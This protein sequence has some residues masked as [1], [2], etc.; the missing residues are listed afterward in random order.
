M[1]VEFASPVQIDPLAKLFDQYRVFYNQPSDIEGAKRFLQARFDNKD[2][3]I[4]VADDDGDLA[5]FT[6]IYPS[7]SSVAMALIWILN[8]LYVAETYRQRGIATAL[9]NAA[10]ERAHQAGA[11]SIQLATQIENS[12]ARRLYEQLGYVKDEEF[13]HYALPVVSSAERSLG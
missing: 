2:S 10:K 9:L 1:K 13:L 8:D 11:A 4:L 7:F 3:I 5:G 12:S 6:Q